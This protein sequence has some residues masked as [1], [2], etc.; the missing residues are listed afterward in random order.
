MIIMAQNKSRRYGVRFSL[1]DL[2]GSQLETI[3]PRLAVRSI[4]KPEVA[5]L[6]ASEAQKSTCPHC[7]KSLDSN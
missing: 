4:P 6:K 2:I 5:I 1:G 7:G 3:K